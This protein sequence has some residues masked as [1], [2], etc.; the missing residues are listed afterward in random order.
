MYI[1]VFITFLALFLFVACQKTENKKLTADFQEMSMS[2]GGISPLENE[3]KKISFPLNSKSLLLNDNFV[4]LAEYPLNQRDLELFYSGEEQARV[5][6]TTVKKIGNRE[7]I[8]GLVA[9]NF[10]NYEGS[11]PAQVIFLSGG[12]NKKSNYKNTIF[13]VMG[14]KF[15][16]LYN[17]TKKF[18][19][20]DES[21]LKD[22]CVQYFVVNSDLSKNEEI[23]CVGSDPS[24]EKN[25]FIFNKAWFRYDDI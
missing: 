14:G 12:E 24:V 19:N 6:M 13:F 10:N 4:N 18:N 1:K 16:I 25:S 8:L 9:V 11:G 2:E 5:L 3:Y 7:Y 21:S 17:E 15:P 23:K 20:I 22:Y